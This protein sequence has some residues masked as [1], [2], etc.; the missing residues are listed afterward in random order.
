MRPAIEFKQ[1]DST[2]LLLEAALAVADDG[3]G[4]GLGQPQL[5]WCSYTL[6]LRVYHFGAP[7]KLLFFDIR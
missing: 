4:L 2:L 6:S 5:E 1:Q 7:P 3:G